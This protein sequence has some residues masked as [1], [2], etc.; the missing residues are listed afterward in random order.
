MAK[1]KT[2]D[3]LMNEGAEAIKQESGRRKC[4]SNQSKKSP[5][6]VIKNSPI[7]KPA[8]IKQEKEIKKIVE[9]TK[10]INSTKEAITS[11]ET[12]NR[13]IDYTIEETT[14]Y[15]VNWF[16]C[17]VM[18]IQACNILISPYTYLK[19][20]FKKKIKILSPDN[21]NIN[22]QAKLIKKAIDNEEWQIFRSDK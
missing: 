18:F 6:L 17:R 12:D 20:K 21:T 9:D 14:M 16:Y 22:L 10:I 8:Q 11:E 19:E 3:D 1:K 7:K 15:D 4:V 5:K 2:V 13:E